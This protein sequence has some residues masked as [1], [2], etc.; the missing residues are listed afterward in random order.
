MFQFAD[1][2][3]TRQVPFAAVGSLRRFVRGLP[4]RVDGHGRQLADPASRSS[5]SRSKFEAVAQATP[6]PRRPVFAKSC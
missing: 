3:G 6:D 2:A 5:S 4:V 1:H